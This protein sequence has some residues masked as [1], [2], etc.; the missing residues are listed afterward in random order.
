MRRRVSGPRPHFQTEAE[1]NARGQ[2][3]A[4]GGREDR[5][6]PNTQRRP[7]NCGLLFPSR[8]LSE[9]ETGPKRTG[10]TSTAAAPRVLGSGPTLHKPPPFGSSGS[11]VTCSLYARALRPCVFYNPHVQLRVL[12]LV[13]STIHPRPPCRKKTAARSVSHPQHP[14][15]LL[16]VPRA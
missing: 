12:N 1:G 13:R 16:H 15:Q 2:A 14:Q 8:A 4:Q 9:T 10:A 6:G 11:T 7:G 3:G 5:G